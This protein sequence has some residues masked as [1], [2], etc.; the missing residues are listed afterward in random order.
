MLMRQ[1][2]VLQ[3][4]VAKCPVNKQL[5]FF[6]LNEVIRLKNASVYVIFKLWDVALK[7][8]MLN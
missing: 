5:T 8:I 2:L 7:S 1:T 3:Y 6:L 4:S